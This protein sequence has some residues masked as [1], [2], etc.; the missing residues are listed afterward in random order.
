MTTPSMNRPRPAKDHPE[1]D[2]PRDTGTFKATL[3]A[4][5]GFLTSDGQPIDP[6]PQD[7]PAPRATL[8]FYCDG[9]D[10]TPRL[11]LTVTS[12]LLVVGVVALIL[13]AL[14]LYVLS[15]DII[16]QADGLLSVLRTSV[17]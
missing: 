5:G 7:Q 9:E 3:P 13:V 1:N 11:W 12:T 16:G 8:P 17:R 15:D 2:E 10:L 4:L 14:L 6:A